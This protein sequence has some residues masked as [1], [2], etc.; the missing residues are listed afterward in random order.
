MF[1]NGNNLV[2]RLL[3]PLGCEGLGKIE[4]SNS[5]GLLPLAVAMITVADSDG[6]IDI[7]TTSGLGLLCIEPMYIGISLDS[8]SI[9]HELIE[10]NPEFVVNTVDEDMLYEAD[11]IRNSKGDRLDKFEMARL[12][13][14]PAKYVQPPSV[15]E[16]SYNLECKVQEA[17]RLGVQDFYV[18]KVLLAYIEETALNGIDSHEEVDT[19]R[20]RAIVEIARAYWSTGRRI[21][22]PKRMAA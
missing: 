20:S 12:T 21:D 18:G 19:Q 14:Q 16:S 17:I 6:N 9:A 1:W 15:L 10:K 7:V 5:T 4:L 11:L 3:E 2:D 22:T 8:D 13:P